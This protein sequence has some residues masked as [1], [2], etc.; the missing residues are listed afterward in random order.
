[1]DRTLTICYTSDT[2]G[3]FSPVDY[4]SARPAPTGLANCAAN[5][6]R[7]GNCLIIDGG[8]TLQ[9]SPFSYWLSQQDAQKAGSVP[10]ALMNLAGVQFVTLGNHDF[11]YGRE[12]LET[13][14][15]NLDAVCLCANVRG[16]PQ[17]RRSAVVT[18]ENG[19]RIGLT[20]I[21]TPFITLWEKPEHLTGITF[22]DP[23]EE[24]RSVLSEL[25]AAAVDL[26][27]CI[28]HG[29]FEA[30]IRT[31]RLLSSTAENQ[32]W[33]IC[34]ELDFDVLLTG[35]QHL[36]LPG[37]RIRNTWTCQP[38]DKAR[39]FIRM[40]LTVSDGGA[41]TAESR[42]I[43]AGDRTQP[44][45]ASF[46]A[47]VE[48]EV[49]LWLD[50]PIGALDV[51]LIPEA[52]LAMALHGSLIANFFNQVQLAASGADLSCTSLANEVR[53]FDSSV[54]IRDVVATYVYPNTLT[55]LRVNRRVLK[56]ALERSAEYFDTDC[57]G[58]LRISDLF[59]LPKEE[60]YNFDYLSGVE[61][62][63]DIS[64]PVGDR[65]LSIRRNGEEIPPDRTYTLCLNNY[66]AAG[67]GDYD[68]YA[69]CEV[70][71][72]I[73]MEIAELIMDYILQHPEITVDKTKWLTVY[74][75]RNR[76]S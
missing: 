30:D 27:V 64:R 4:A 55:V 31:G 23:V 40:D 20:G 61:A 65:V 11:N 54:S 58:A 1:M 8:D 42:L 72:S 12:V 75:G 21:T 68:F 51:P 45:M 69:D 35:H 62:E 46:L 50:R 32:A 17:V 49:S 18:L 33:R 52:H 39:S 59:L 13:Y 26:T 56:A 76:L 73:P 19:L 16:L 10:A 53:G 66:R 47:P 70:V 6:A 14:L 37:A 2:H 24:A 60:H 63:I 41:V 71:S 25:R 7:G 43:A 9:G 28:Y 15:N 38:P 36:P 44:E 34:Q 22:T 67:S 5:F 3:Y 48:E 74:N 29:G 57:S